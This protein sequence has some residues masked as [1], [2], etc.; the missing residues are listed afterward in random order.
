MAAKRACRL[1][2]EGQMLFARFGKE[3]WNVL[4]ES[5]GLHWQESYSGCD[6]KP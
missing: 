2:F 1:E 3:F 5:A 6:K 4:A